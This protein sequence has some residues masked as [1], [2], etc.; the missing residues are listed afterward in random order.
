M[1][2]RNKINLYTS[3]LFAVLLILINSTIYFSFHQLI[4]DGE[5]NTAKK[6]I[7][8]TTRDFSDS[9]G[10]IPEDDLLRSYVPISGMIQIVSEKN[11]VTTAV[12]SP[13][14]QASI[15]RKDLFYQQEISRLMVY[16]KK[17]YIFE[18]MP[19]ILPDGT[20]ANL[21]IIKGI[22]TATDNLKILRYVMLAVTMI[23]FIPVILSSKFLSNLITQPILSMIHTMQEIRVKG[24]FKRIP[25]EGHSNDELFKMGE[26]FNH[27]M[28]LLEVNYQ[29]QTE[30]V[31]NASHELKTPLTII[32]SYASLLKR[33]GFS[34]PDL[35]LESI[36]AILSEAIQMKEMTEQLLLLAKQSEQWSVQKEKIQLSALVEQTVH[37]FKSAYDLNIECR[38]DHES[39]LF[40]ET[41]EK[42]LKQLMFI[43]LDN[44]RKY[45]DQRLTVI[46]GME[47]EKVFIKMIDR[48]IG[49]PKEDLPKV[50][51][52]F[53]RVDK[54]RSRKQGGSG[55]G[56]SL[57]K[58]IADAID[59]HILLVSEE[60]IGT[61]VTLVI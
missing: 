22:Q 41:D 59:V 6:E 31:S 11:Q 9:I 46:T 19:I 38:Q 55:L 35:L 29:K 57:A 23:A 27:M 37:S 61:T 13:T 14:E 40:V 18:S 32:E 28:D 42:K 3:F 43:F 25:L 56:L 47:K 51:D 1:K 60:G 21:Q 26:T 58:E 44:A 52:R 12:T 20:I 5:L 54:A 16:Q 33:R 30:F 7:E 17:S 49:I 48:G 36:E 2:L 24:R 50:F 4:F 53:Y 15:Q 34:D 8:K 10:I 45:S 39:P